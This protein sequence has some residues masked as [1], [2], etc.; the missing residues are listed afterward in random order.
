MPGMMSHAEVAEP[1]TS[2]HVD[3]SGPAPHARSSSLL[4][5]PRRPPANG[6]HSA[7][8]KVDNTVHGSLVLSNIGRHGAGRR[9]ATD[10][11]ARTL[12]TGER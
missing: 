8:G 10:I 6:L 12:Q 1:H 3:D 11:K 2:S 5:K 4:S 7:K 9:H